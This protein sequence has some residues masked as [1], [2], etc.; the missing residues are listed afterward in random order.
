MLE[1]VLLSILHW[2]TKAGSIVDAIL[3]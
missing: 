3:W 1:I 2:P